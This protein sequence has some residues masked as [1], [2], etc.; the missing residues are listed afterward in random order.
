MILTTERAL[1]AGGDAI[2]RAPDG[3]VIFVQGACPEEQVRVEVVKDNKTFLRA[4]VIEVI[5][6]GASRVSPRCE[7]FGVCGG[8]TLQ[9]VSAEAQRA[10][11]EAV[12]FE[13]VARI[14]GI[15]EP[16]K[17]DPTWSGAPY[18]YRSRARV[19]VT[20]EAI[21]YR[22]L[23]S[24][25]VVD[26][27]TCPILTPAVQAELTALRRRGSEPGDPQAKR[28]ASPASGAGSADLLRAYPG[29]AELG[30]AG[31]GV[32][33]QS[34]DEGNEA[35]V[36]H[37]RALAEGATKVLELYAGSGNFT[38][39]LPGNVH[40]I[41]SNA[42]ATKLAQ[43]RG[44]DIET[45]DVERALRTAQPVYDLIVL[46]PP[47]TGA[48]AKVLEQILRLRAA[49]IIYVSCDPATFSRDV[50]TLSAAYRLDRLRAFDLYPQTSHVEVIGLLIA[51]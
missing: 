17:K 25:E 30:G 38:R 35:M 19:A 20:R 31:P 40:A 22:K 41:E 14:G 2:A 21:G 4:R 39:V 8:C 11:K 51:R 42:A 50:R 7:H 18:A 32:F 12:V 46:D 49:R 24:R 37:V 45:A 33:A 36:S 43:K 27:E 5:A 3:R 44:L 23:D 6:A 9:H 15:A 16:P 28:A 10:S 29:E 13:T 48:T 47:R 34:N 1:A 26:V